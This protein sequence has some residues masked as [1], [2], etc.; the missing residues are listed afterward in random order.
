M[1][2]NAFLFGLALAVLGIALA[3]THELLGPWPGVNERNVGRIREGMSLR[4]VEA[5]LGG[6]GRWHGRAGSL[7][8]AQTTYVW[9][10]TGGLAVVFFGERHG[11]PPVVTFS[12]YRPVAGAC[13]PS[14]LRAWL[15]LGAP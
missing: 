12:A 14:P 7:R 5:I 1:S 13:A 4:E 15:G 11:Q 3:L 10:G 2:K 8:Y 9:Q 6:R